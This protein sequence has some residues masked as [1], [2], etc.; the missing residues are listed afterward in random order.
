MAS[1]F[2]VFFTVSIMKEVIYTKQKIIDYL[3]RKAFAWWWADYITDGRDKKAHRKSLFY[4]KLFRM[5]CVEEA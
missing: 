4:N 3:G 5:F 2:F 1:S